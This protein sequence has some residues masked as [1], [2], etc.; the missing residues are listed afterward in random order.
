MVHSNCNCLS[1]FCIGFDLII[2]FFRIAKKGYLLERIVRGPYASA[3]YLSA[4]SALYPLYDVQDTMS[5][6]VQSESREKGNFRNGLSAPDFAIFSA[7]LPML[8]VP[9]FAIFPALLPMLPPPPT[10]KMYVYKVRR[11]ISQ[12]SSKLSWMSQNYFF[13]LY[14]CYVIRG[15]VRVIA[16][17]MIV[18]HVS[19]RRVEEENTPGSNNASI[20]INC[21]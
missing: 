10:K 11:N 18:L 4:V 7:L 16:C 15:S 12:R 6:S 5:N 9:D 14:F 20:L 19:F 8:P 21:L 17:L 13:C 1:P 2:H 3:V